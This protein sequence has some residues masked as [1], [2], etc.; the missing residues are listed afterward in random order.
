M[1]DLISTLRTAFCGNLGYRFDAD[2]VELQ[3]DIAGPRGWSDQGQWTLQLWADET[4]K[5]AEL[6]LGRLRGQ[7]RSHR[8]ATVSIR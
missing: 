1:S 7:R 4:V 3:A 5:V 2:Q 6:S 8:P